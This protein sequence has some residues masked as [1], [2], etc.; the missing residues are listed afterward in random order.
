MS[1]ANDPSMVLTPRT[2]GTRVRSIDAL[3]GFTMLWIIG[4][5]AVV[6]SLWHI[7]QNPTTEMLRLQMKHAGWEGFHFI[8]LIFPLFLFLVGVVLP[9]SI[10]GRVERGVPRRQLYLHIAKRTAI[11]ILLGWI[12]YGLLHFQ[13]SEMRW[14]TVLGR[15]GICYGLA[16]LLLIHGN[17]KVEMLL[18]TL[19]L[20]GY[21]AA[22]MF[23]PVPGVGAGVLTP[24]GCLTT[25]LDQQ[26]LPGKLGLGLYDRQGILSTFT[27]L[28]TTLVGVLAG[29]WL[30]SD[31]SSNVKT[32]GLLVAGLV[33]LGAGW[34]WGRTFFISRNVWTSSF[35]L[36]AAGWSLLLLALFYWIIDVKGYTK[37]FFVLTVIGMNAITIWVGQHAIDFGYT[38]DFLVGGA[39]RNLTNIQPT[40]LA[41]TE[42]TLKGVFL[43]FLFRHH[44]FL[45]A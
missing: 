15:I 20:V 19:I 25:Y 17:W 30:R 28:A 26:L 3:R 1:N 12:N 5:G 36:Y 14:S 43:W 23:V 2:I 22:V 38:A 7:W 31:W 29:R 42:L 18:I 44:V 21:W 33:T 16:A 6:S 32:L 41:L 39:I 8:D 40:I 9:F 37:W 45:K 4:G 34:A 27:S 24:E 13:W 10:L 11:L 35:V